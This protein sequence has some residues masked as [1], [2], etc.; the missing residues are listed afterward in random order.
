MTH[1]ALLTDSYGA[2]R[3]GVTVAVQLLRE[4]LLA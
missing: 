1:I 3:N 2:T 4:Q